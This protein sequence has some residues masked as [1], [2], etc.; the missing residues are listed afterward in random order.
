MVAIS[1]TKNINIIHVFTKTYTIWRGLV[2]QKLYQKLPV[3]FPLKDSF[4]IWSFDHFFYIFR[5]FNRIFGLIWSIRPFRQ[6]MRFFKHK[7]FMIILLN[8]DQLCIIFLYKD[9]FCTFIKL[10]TIRTT[11]L[12]SRRT[13]P[14]IFTQG[15]L[16]FI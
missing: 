14:I 2:H 8:T 10:G 4:L 3:F 7:P 1:L 15:Q 5:H 12:F 6:I 13:I 11:I 16:T 9:H